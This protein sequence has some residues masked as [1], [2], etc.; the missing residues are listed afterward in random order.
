MLILGRRRG[1][2]SYGPYLALGGL[3]VMLWPERFF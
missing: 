3:I 2:Y 1:Y